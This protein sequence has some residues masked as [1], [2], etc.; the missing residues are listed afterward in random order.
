[1]P[2]LLEVRG[3]HTEFRTGAGLVRAVDGISYTVEQGETVA[4]V[5]ES[6]SGKSVGALSILRLIPDP[7]GRITGRRDPVRRPRPARPLR[8]GDARD[9]RPRHRHGVPGA[10]D[11]A[12]SR[13]DHRAA[14]HRDAGAASGR[15]PARRRSGARSSS[16]RWSASPTPA[17]GCKQ[18]P[19]QLSGGMRQRVM[20]AIAL[21]CNPKLIIADEPTTALDVTIQAQ[22][23]ELMK[24][25]TRP[26]QRRADRHHPQSR[27]G[28]PLCQ[29]RERHVCRPDRRGRQR[30]CDLSRSRGIPTRWR[31]C[32]PCRGSTSR[33]GRA[34]IR[35]TASRPTSPGS[36]AAAPS[37]RAAASPSTQCARGQPAAGAGRRGE[38]CRRLL[39]ERR[40]ASAAQDVAA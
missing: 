29:P 22:I 15:R 13:A 19:H 17:G 31:C 20:I 27:R 18:Y 4:I 37:A 5:G 33:G 32:A 7:P 12:Q 14:D 11:L 3:L 1:M 10:D 21:A 35:S 6:G 16:W 36:T 26:A 24:S 38:P 40:A 28:R 25:L 9:P 34:S 39:P 8:S 23:L 30:R 2:P